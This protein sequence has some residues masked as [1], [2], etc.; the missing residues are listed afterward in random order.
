MMVSGFDVRERALPPFLDN[1]LTIALP[2]RA[3]AIPVISGVVEVAIFR[4]NDSAT[5]FV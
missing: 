2:K 1:T 3:I 5:L 4:D